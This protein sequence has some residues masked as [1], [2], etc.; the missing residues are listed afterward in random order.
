MLAD[1]INS[2]VAEDAQPSPELAKLEEEIDNIDPS[3]LLVGP[4][5]RLLVRSERGRLAFHIS[6]VPTSGGGQ[7]P[8]QGNGS[9]YGTPAPKLWPQV[10]SQDYLLRIRG[11]EAYL[12]LRKNGR[13]VFNGRYVGVQRGLDGAWRG[14]WRQGVLK[15]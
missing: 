1:L 12:L 11:R 3:E 6:D 7:G 13:V 9:F 5:A 15:E 10:A 14:Q 8:P 4:T 2:L